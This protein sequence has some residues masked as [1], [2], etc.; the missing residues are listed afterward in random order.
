MCHS[1]QVGAGATINVRMDKEEEACMLSVS[2]ESRW[3]RSMPSLV[4]GERMSDILIVQS[5]A[6]EM[7]G[8]KTLFVHVGPQN[9]V[10]P[11]DHEPD[12]REPLWS[13]SAVL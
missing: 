7:W 13:T 1:S 8:L 2:L 10:F 6:P 5:C 12:Q 9:N 3:G 4:D 11:F